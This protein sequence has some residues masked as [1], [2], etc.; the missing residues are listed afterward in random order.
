MRVPHI[1]SENTRLAY[2]TSPASFALVGEYD[3]NIK[4]EDFNWN[5]K[6]IPSLVELCVQIINKNFFQNPILNKLP[7][8]ERN[9]LLEILSVEL[10]LELTIPLINVINQNN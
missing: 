10:P 6:L 2:N 1:I 9:H 4:A 3:R 8:L 7:C 5:A